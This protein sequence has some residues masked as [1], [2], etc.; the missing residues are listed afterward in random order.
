MKRFA[1]L[2]VMLVPALLFSGC[3]CD[4]SVP[5]L[6][7]P[8]P[9]NAGYGFSGLWEL[10]GSITRGEGGAPWAVHWEI[11]FPTGG[12]AVEVED[13]LIAESFPEQVRIIFRVTPPPP[14]SIVTQA[15]VTEEGDFTVDVD[16]NATFKVEVK[17]GCAAIPLSL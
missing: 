14:G 8:L 10:R 6:V 2:I 4:F 17:T 15:I 16:A 12:Y 5:A 9:G 11:T 1:L 7:L 3:P 13:V